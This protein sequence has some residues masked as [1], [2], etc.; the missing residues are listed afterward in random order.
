MGAPTVRGDQRISNGISRRLPANGRQMISVVT[1]L[2]H[3]CTCTPSSAHRHVVGLVAF[4]FAESESA[5]HSTFHACPAESRTESLHLAD[6]LRRL[7]SIFEEQLLNSSCMLRTEIRA[8]LH[9][10]MWPPPPPSSVATHLHPP[11]PL[12]CAGA[13]TSPQPGL[14]S[15]PGCL[16]RPRSRE[17]GTGVT[18]RGVPAGPLRSDR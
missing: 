17:G 8:E 2:K 16:A 10:S 1:Q 15:Q 4:S 6:D 13:N 9:I 12:S 5:H 18:P 7:S 14:E 11:Q 3:L